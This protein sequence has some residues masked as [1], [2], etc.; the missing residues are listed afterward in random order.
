MWAGPQ[1]YGMTRNLVIGEALCIFEQKTW[2]RGTYTN[3]NYELVTKD[4]ITNLFPLKVLQF[5]KRYLRRVLYNPRETNIRDLIFWINE[6]VE[7]LEKFPTFVDWKC[8][9]DD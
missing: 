4:L 8:L 5:Q 7:Y 3:S 2:E 1:K 6:M 9:L